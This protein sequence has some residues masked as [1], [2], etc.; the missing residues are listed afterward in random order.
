MDRVLSIIIPVFQAKDTLKR[1]VLSCTMQKNLQ[2]GEFEIILIDDGSTDGSAVICDELSNE[3]GD[4][5]KVKHTKNCGVS[6]A[7]NLGIETATG[8]FICFVDADDI[9]EDRFATAL[10]TRADDGTSLVDE[11]DSYVYDGKIS[12]Y[13]YIESSI[14]NKNTHV[15]GKLFLRQIIVD[16]HIM[17]KEGLTIGEDLLFL[18]DFALLQGRE[19]S[20]RCV[21]GGLYHYEDNPNG[22][23]KKAFKE[24]Y[25]DELVCWK[26]AEDRLLAAK[27]FISEY[28]FVNVAVS[29]IMTALLVAGKLSVQD[30][31]DRDD[32]VT[33]LVV[34]RVSDQLRHALKTRGAFAALSIGYKIKVCIFRTNPY[35]YLKIY[36]NY[37]NR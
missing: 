13:Q 16:N 19:R 31:T 9:I 7:R 22:A 5:I 30:E 33:E 12:G 10:L 37:K 28:A 20:I 11:S 36:G 17:F 35:L 27:G 6:H 8:K 18:I 34:T 26:D 4:F 25:M 1:C 15:W 32:M 14:L 23:M 29:Q 2:Q 3:Y 24:S 21:G